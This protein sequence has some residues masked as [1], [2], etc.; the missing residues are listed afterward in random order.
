[1]ETLKP[2]HY[3][4]RAS[5]LIA[6]LFVQ[7]NL[8]KPIGDELTFNVLEFVGS[9]HY[10]AQLLMTANGARK[11]EVLCAYIEQFGLLEI[12]EAA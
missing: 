3:A 12:P 2:E 4:D 10:V 5:E 7:G 9:R 8:G 1:M 6:A 11:Y